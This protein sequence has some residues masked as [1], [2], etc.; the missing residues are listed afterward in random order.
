MSNEEIAEIGNLLI[1]LQEGIH[2]F[3][4]GDGGRW[5]VARGDDG[6][7][8]QWEN[9]LVD[10]VDELRHVAAHQVGAPHTAVEDGIPTYE[11]WTLRQ[12]KSLSARAMARNVKHL[13]QLVT[14]GNHVTILEFTVDD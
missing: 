10:A 14:Q 4:V 12:I 3:L 9:L 5:T 13:N 11:Q 7:I 8:G 1:F 6:L 2:A